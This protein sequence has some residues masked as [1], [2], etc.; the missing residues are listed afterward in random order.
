MIRI[1]RLEGGDMGLPMQISVGLEGR[2]SGLSM[3]Y[4]AFAKGRLQGS[5]EYVIYGFLNVSIRC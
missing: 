5:T 2:E 3:L 4:A 1:N